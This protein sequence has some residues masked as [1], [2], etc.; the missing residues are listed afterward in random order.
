MQHF[1][2]IKTIVL[3]YS[4]GCEILNGFFQN[5]YICCVTHCSPHQILMQPCLDIKYGYCSFIPFFKIKKQKFLLEYKK[6]KVT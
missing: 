6:R 1:L 2:S 3:Q 4:S 5:N